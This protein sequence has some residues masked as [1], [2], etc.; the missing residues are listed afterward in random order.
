MKEIDA[1]LD[2]QPELA[3]EMVELDHQ[4]R[5][6]HKELQLYNDHKTFVYTHPL[7]RRKKQEADALSELLELKASHPEAFIEECYSITHNLKRYKKLLSNDKF[8]SHDERERC[9]KNM[10]RYSLRQLIA[11]KIVR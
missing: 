2:E 6:A 1:L 9:R 10:E 7:T 4:N 8:T 5:Q 3:L 11:Q